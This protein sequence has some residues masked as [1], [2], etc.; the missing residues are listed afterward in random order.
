MSRFPAGLK[1]DCK[2]R[3]RN[4]KLVKHESDKETNEPP[5]IA[6]IVRLR[7]FTSIYHRKK[8][9]GV[10]PPPGEKLKEGIRETKLV[11]SSKLSFTPESRIG[12]EAIYLGIGFA[13]ADSLH[14]SNDRGKGCH[15][16]KR[17]HK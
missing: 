17:A 3:E 13:V 6:A 15:L 2:Q 4:R 8:F 10:P 11:A 16:D 7:F 12:I 9:R 5:L 1:M 14:R